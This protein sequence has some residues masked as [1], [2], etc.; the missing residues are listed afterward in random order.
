MLH[1]KCTAK[2]TASQCPAMRF[3][4]AHRSIAGIMQCF[5]LARA[6]VAS[7][8]VGCGLHV[9]LCC[10][11]CCSHRKTLASH[12]H[13]WVCVDNRS[14]SLLQV[15]LFGKEISSLLLSAEHSCRTTQLQPCCLVS[16]LLGL[17]Q[18]GSEE[19]APNLSRPPWDRQAGCACEPGSCQAPTA[20]ASA[21]A[22]VR[23]TE[24]ALSAEVC[25]TKQVLRCAAVRPPLGRRP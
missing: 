20:S 22:S 25:T 11:L 3:Y 7:G 12:L 21:V 6:C 9:Q 23:R 16:T 1:L 19:H 5:P 15:V 4:A 24:L 17:Y 14:T 2:E 8:R 10:S 13:P 18:Q